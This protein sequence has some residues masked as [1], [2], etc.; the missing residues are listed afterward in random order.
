MAPDFPRFFS[1]AFENDSEVLA[2]NPEWKLDFEAST[3]GAAGD[4]S[5]DGNTFTFA[6]PGWSGL[7]ADLLGGWE[8]DSVKLTCGAVPANEPHALGPFAL[9]SFEAL[10]RAADGKSSANPSTTVGHLSP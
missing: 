2:W 4:F 9:A 3:D 1:V 10:L 5:E 8:K 7:V 6:A